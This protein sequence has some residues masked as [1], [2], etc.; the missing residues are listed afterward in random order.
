MSWAKS[1]VALEKEKL[2]KPTIT[3]DIVKLVSPSEACSREKQIEFVR[4]IL[5]WE[6]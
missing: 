6:K 3:R 2:G 5:S 4:S 1:Q